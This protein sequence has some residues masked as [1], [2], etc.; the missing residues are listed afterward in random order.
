MS[1]CHETISVKTKSLIS[2]L[3]GDHKISFQSKAVL[4]PKTWKVTYCILILIINF[5]KKT[6]NEPELLFLHNTNAIGTKFWLNI[7]VKGNGTSKS[8]QELEEEIRSLSTKQNMS[9]FGGVIWRN[10][11]WRSYQPS[12]PQPTLSLHLGWYSKNNFFLQLLLSP[13]LFN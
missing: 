11:S 9:C 8:I 5:I 2:N 6:I 4:H 3:E 12:G 13:P 10:K 1:F 7:A